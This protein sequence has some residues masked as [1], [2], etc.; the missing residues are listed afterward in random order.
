MPEERVGI[1]LEVA[2]ADEARAQVGGLVDQFGKALPQA[3]EYSGRS[4]ASLA[5]SFGQVG[6]AVS[7]AG[8]DARKL[9]SD[10]GTIKPTFADIDTAV[11]T[12]KGAFS[13]LGL[14]MSKGLK[15]F[16]ADRQAASIKAAFETI[17]TS[18]FSTSEDVAR[19]QAAMNAKLADLT[20]GT[21]AAGAGA[22]VLGSSLSK[23]SGLADQAGVQIGSLQIG[24]NA[25]KEIAQLA[26]SDAGALAITLGT[27]V[28]AF[29]ALTGALIGATSHLTSSFQSI[30]Q[31]S[32]VSGLAAGDADDL[33]DAMEAV[34]ISTETLSM[35]I[36]K[37]SADVESGG[38]ALQKLGI[39]VQ[40]IQTLGEGELFQRAIEG[41]QDLGSQSEKTSAL[42]E[43]FGARFGRQFAELVRD[44]AM[45]L[46]ELKERVADLS[47]WT[48]EMAQ[49]ARELGMAQTFL[50]NATGGVI[51]AIGSAFAPALTIATNKMTDLIVGMRKVIEDGPELQSIIDGVSSVF[52]SLW[53]ALEPLLPL[54]KMIGAAAMLAFKGFEMGINF[55]MIPITALMSS[56]G[57]IAQAMMKLAQ[58]D[59]SGAWASITKGFSDADAAAKRQTVRFQESVASTNALVDRY[60]GLGTVIKEVS[61]ESDKASTGKKAPGPS[62]QQLQEQV[63]QLQALKTEFEA[64]QS[65]ADASF[66]L[67]MVFDTSA[68]TQ[69]E[70]LMAHMTALQESAKLTQ[71]IWTAQQAAIVAD[72]TKKT[73][74]QIKS[75]L[76]K[77]QAEFRGAMAA[78]TSGIIADV[79]S[80][81]KVTQ[82]EWRKQSEFARKAAEDIN[83]VDDAL[84]KMYLDVS[85][86][87]AVL[88]QDLFSTGEL[89]AAL[90]K[91]ERD[92]QATMAKIS[93][94]MG[95]LSQP[96]ELQLAA[97]EQATKNKLTS[98]ELLWKNYGIKASADLAESF[99]GFTSAF[100]PMVDQ[101]A[102]KIRLLP[103]VIQASTESVNAFI[104]AS[105]GIPVMERSIA[106][107]QATFGGT[108]EAV[109]RQEIAIRETGQTW[110]QLSAK[111]DE[112]S[113][114]AA[115]FVAEA[116]KVATIDAAWKQAGTA[117][118]GLQEQFEAAELASTLTGEAFLRASLQVKLFGDAFDPLDPAMVNAVNRAMELQRALDRMIP[119]NFQSNLDDIATKASL[120]GDNFDA[121]GAQVS[122]AQ[123][124][125]EATWDAMKRGTASFED[126]TAAA[127]AWNAAIA[128]Q[129]L[130]KN[131]E[132]AFL[133][134][135]DT[136][137]KMADGM[138]QGTLDIADAF[139]NLGRSLLTNF[140]QLV[141][142]QVFDPL[143]QAAASFATGFFKILMSGVSSAGD[144]FFKQ[145]ASQFANSVLGGLG[146]GVGGV[147][148]GG[149]LG[150][151]II[152]WA[153]SIGQGI[154]NLPSTISAATSAWEA[155]N[156]SLNVGAST[157]DSLSAGVSTF[158]DNLG[159]GVGVLGTTVAALG[160]MYS[161]YSG[162]MAFTEGRTNAGIGTLGGMAIGAG[163]GFLL[164]GG[165]FGALVGAGIGGG[166]GGLLGG[167][168]DEDWDYIHKLRQQQ[169]TNTALTAMSETSGR[170]LNAPN[171]A[172]LSSSF[173]QPIIG[174]GSSTAG[175]LMRLAEESQSGNIKF[176]GDLTFTLPPDVAKNITT[177]LAGQGFTAQDF[178][179][180]RVG[181]VTEMIAATGPPGDIEGGI[182]AWQDLML[183]LDA[184]IRVLEGSEKAIDRITQ[185]QATAV[186]GAMLGDREAMDFV[187]TFNVA[188]QLKHDEFKAGD[189]IRAQLDAIASGVE[190]GIDAIAAAATKAFIKSPE[191]LINIMDVTPFQQAGEEISETTERVGAA[192]LRLGQQSR[193]LEAELNA[194]TKVD[195]VPAMREAQA[196]IDRQLAVLASDLTESAW[197]PTVIAE[198][199]AQ[200]EALIKQ[201]YE[202]ELATFQ[203]LVAQI[204]AGTES[205]ANAG[206]V[207]AAH[208][209]V[210]AASG[211]SLSG[212]TTTMLEFAD[213]LPTVEARLTALSTATRLW[214]ASIQESLRTG[215]M[216]AAITSS[217][218][219][220]GGYQA[221][222]N[223][224]MQI[225]DPTQRLAALS[226]IFDGLTGATEAAIAATNA[227]YGALADAAQKFLAIADSIG[228]AIGSAAQNTASV[229][230]GL[231]KVG[232]N[233][234]ELVRGA[235]ALV[236][237]MPT[238]ASKMKALAGASDL[239]AA[240]LG[241]ASQDR[242]EQA[243][244][245]EAT[246]ELFA[247]I[248]TTLDYANSLSDPTQRLE[249]VG[250]LTQEFGKAIAQ[251]EQTIGKPFQDAID[252][253]DPE[254]NADQ[255]AVLVAQQDAAID[256]FLKSLGPLGQELAVAL[257][258]SG[259]SA[260]KAVA[261]AQTELKGII[262]DSALTAE[263][264]LLANEAAQ[265]AAL[266]AIING[267]GPLIKSVADA[268]IFAGKDIGGSIA[269][270]GTQLESV[271]GKVAE[272]ENF[273][274]SSIASLATALGGVKAALDAHII[275]LANIT[276][277]AVFAPAATGIDRL[278]GSSAGIPILA[279]PGERIFSARNT[280]ILDRLGIT[281]RALNRMPQA[282]TGMDTIPDVYPGPGRD[283]VQVPRPGTTDTLGSGI[284]REA[285]GTSRP[286]AGVGREVPRLERESISSPSYFSDNR[287]FADIY[288]ATSFWAA[289]NS[290]NP[291]RT[292]GG[293]TTRPMTEEEIAAIDEKF[294]ALVDTL[295]N[296]SSVIAR[297]SDLLADANVNL[298]GVSARLFRTSE[299]IG[300]VDAKSRLLGA[301]M[302][303]LD[304][305]LRQTTDVMGTLASVAPSAGV[306]IK[307]LADLA[308]KSKDLTQLTTAF[309]A[310]AGAA[311]S[312]QNS[313]SAAYDRQRAQAESNARSQQ[314]ALTDQLETLREIV[315]MTED[316]E[317]VAD[318]LRD[319]I[320]DLLTSD[321]APPDPYGQFAFAQSE[322]VSALASFRSGPTTEGAGRVQELARAMLDAATKVYTK[323]DPAYQLLFDETIRA[324]ESVQM[325]ATAR[326]ASQEDLLAQIAALETRSQEINDATRIAVLQLDMNEAAARQAIVD[327]V[328]PDLARIVEAM[329]TAGNTAAVQAIDLKSVSVNTKNIATDINAI[330]RSMGAGYAAG[331][332]SMPRTT[333]ALVHE[334]ERIVPAEDNVPGYMIGPNGEGAAGDLALRTAGRV[335]T[336]TVSGGGG[337]TFNITVVSNDPD[338][339]W[340]VLR[341]RLD[342]YLRPGRRGS[343][344][345]QGR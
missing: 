287:S 173:G 235:I 266:N 217:V 318:S 334:G 119:A 181:S 62:V 146:G 267:A 317:R 76:A 169:R 87:G 22:S 231:N 313:V 161:L 252:K 82:D 329:T 215:D 307:S 225:D 65:V 277:T 140:V 189:A 17:R 175:I 52:V 152:D 85:R 111:T 294:K 110:E 176:D 194:M 58:G 106:S 229:L 159:A 127:N 289:M 220:L 206:N 29:A 193:S 190:G 263:N 186:P 328:A 293:T 247:T 31:F 230:D 37:I 249:M 333:W 275:G 242:G 171:L 255:I 226:Q 296:A 116:A 3:M 213:S 157:W 79:G 166:L 12:T 21:V 45:S 257:K 201:R 284:G 297:Y 162:I 4:A 78:I 105:L 160:A 137:T 148:G 238:A 309:D 179:S 101:L 203:A 265:T 115:K 96:T 330:R 33:A 221:A 44:G 274:A 46:E 48:E 227:Y 54:L 6:P 240:G 320:F 302:N 191:A 306:A 73:P 165:P 195:P 222:F 32:A 151:S 218:E 51:D 117:M 311:T 154:G 269:T 305:E 81:S 107:L 278:D 243:G 308:I 280:R 20:K 326:G 14:D 155:F 337:N 41:I 196:D 11:A 80:I 205:I 198:N 104:R 94:G 199:F 67:R 103:D 212:M 335:Q 108:T 130:Y 113:K 244:M 83:K 264:F 98:L 147:G 156:I 61:A 28:V 204:Q 202:M 123:K 343:R 55:V 232:V 250:S 188:E 30:K 276:V 304:V 301:A 192:L 164:G 197:D 261:D 172:D 43:L 282:A 319:Q 291:G 283:S 97:I 95:E 174:T 138:I 259:G 57:G 327:F 75:E 38:A 344:I 216:D 177:W 234:S 254:K 13:T 63:A 7:K 89:D 132:S 295:V 59:F 316:W 122:A 141:L 207:F 93:A 74:D 211:V 224:A 26:T 331:I 285:D 27:G 298:S 281:N 68:E 124:N 128:D 314:D 184:L 214:Q 342:E 312:A 248:K 325:T 66:K 270:A 233:T 324:L 16:D 18:S 1:R 158:V 100:D 118:R 210:A 145:G 19:A 273:V 286:D 53:E 253:L 300:T 49:R 121:M 163:A 178:S 288:G 345:T 219:L 168:F 336:E 321:L 131:I 340:E 315:R 182:E 341:P 40:D 102:R 153:M 338:R 72:T 9:G 245:N 5:A 114:S 143:L 92:F 50:A 135:T 129:T 150:G 268:M 251:I 91:I 292:G 236:D 260:A 42:I 187:A 36:F 84:A 47:P 241:V 208:A 303:I 133:S 99:K 69:I 86:Q 258:E 134:I 209:A 223:D 256:A 70:S 246:R 170:I 272:A 8:A 126:V 139:A 112:A 183:G 144:A 35:A 239:F 323:P 60:M 24:L 237:Q 299:L 271:L 23:L 200:Q 167:L 125:F 290:Q 39:S 109:K 25:F 56:I 90:T 136:F 310:I 2:G 71:E 142:H 34:G 322:F 228:G 77:G 185:K 149:L 339:A 15:Q 10:L 279:H 262:G 332:A 120:L 88:T 64:I 180:G